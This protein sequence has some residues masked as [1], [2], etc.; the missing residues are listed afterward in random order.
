MIAAPGRFN[1][2]E[3]PEANTERVRCIQRLVAGVCAPSGWMD[4]ELAGC[5]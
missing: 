2:R 3:H 1:L 4:W 5:Q